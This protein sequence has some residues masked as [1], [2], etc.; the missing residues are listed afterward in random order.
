MSLLGYFHVI[1]IDRTMKLNKIAKNILMWSVPFYYIART[2]LEI[3]FITVLHQ[4]YETCKKSLHPRYSKVRY[5]LVMA[6]LCDTL[7]SKLLQETEEKNQ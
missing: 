7:N 4:G 6:S 1:L 2:F 3:V 5:K